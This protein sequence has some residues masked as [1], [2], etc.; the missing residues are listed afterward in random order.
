MLGA[1]FGRSKN[2]SLDRNIDN[3]FEFSP[4]KIIKE[5]DYIPIVSI[6][7]TIIHNFKGENINTLSQLSSVIVGSFIYYL[8]LK[9]N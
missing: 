1:V 2:S 7:V 4:K 9:K 8:N 6:S 5:M 3:S